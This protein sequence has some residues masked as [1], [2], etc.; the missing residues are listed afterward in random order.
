VLAWGQQRGTVVIPKSTH[1]KYIDENFGSQDIT[2]TE[3]ELKE[4]AKKDKKYRFLN[5]GKDWGVDLFEG[6]DGG[7]KKEED[8]RNE[9]L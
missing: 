6:L 3:G 7:S 5:P 1:E 9:D 8:D 2:F 4:V